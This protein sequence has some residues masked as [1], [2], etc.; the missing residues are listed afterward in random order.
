MTVKLRLLSIWTPRRIL[1][2]EL[3]RVAALTTGALDGLLRER[4][5]GRRV[6]DIPLGGSLEERRAAMAANQRARVAALVEALGAEEAVRAGREALFPVGERLGREARGRLGVGDGFGD[7]VRAAKV[8]Y[9][10]L[11]INF[12]IAREGPGAGTESEPESEPGATLLVDRCALSEHYTR[13]ACLILSAAD[14]GVVRGL[15]PA[16]GMEFRERITEGA[17]KC[18]AQLRLSGGGGEG[19]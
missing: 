1:I 13:E 4:A 9:R 8:L 5:P 11:G 16:M 19:R 2:R 3:D 15:N 17:P 12:D 18:V 6:A 7:L 14:E 10:V